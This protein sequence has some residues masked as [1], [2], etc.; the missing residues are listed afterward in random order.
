M[1][2]RACS[3]SGRVRFQRSPAHLHERIRG[4]LSGAASLTLGGVGG[5]RYPEQVNGLRRDPCVNSGEFGRQVPHAIVINRGSG[6]SPTP[7]VGFVDF[8]APRVEF[9]ELSPNPASESDGVELACAINDLGLEFGMFIVGHDDVGAHGDLVQELG[10]L[11]GLARCKLAG[12]ACAIKL[13]MRSAP[14]AIHRRTARVTWC[15][16]ELASEELLD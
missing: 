9:D 12:V 14:L 5:I 11:A 2:P 13:L 10:H 6:R 3:G 4:D 15:H 7:P 1:G 8:C 16:A